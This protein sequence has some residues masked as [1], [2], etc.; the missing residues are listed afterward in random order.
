MT[1]VDGYVVAVP[2]AN[3]EA[4]IEFAQRSARIFKEH[5]ALAVVEAWGDDVPQGELTSFPRAVQCQ[6]N[7]TVVFSWVIWPSRGVRDAGWE[8]ARQHPHMSE[9]AM[10]CDGKRLIYGG[11]EMIVNV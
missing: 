10:P 2:N 7:E 1:Y 9:G 4:Y 8:K 11:F 5:G 6:E 3:K